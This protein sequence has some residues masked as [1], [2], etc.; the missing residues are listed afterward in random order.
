MAR[1]ERVFI[2]GEEVAQYDGAYKVTKG[3]GKKYGAERV[4]DTPISESGFTGLAIG[5]ALMGLR[6]VLEFMTMNFSLQAVDHIFNSSAKL[7]HMSNG[8]LGGSIV[9]RG[10]NGPAASVAAQ[11]SQCFASMYSNV[12][13]LVVLSPY[14]AEDCKGL[15]KAAIRGPNPTVFLENELLYSKSFRVPAEV[16]SKEFVLPIGKAKVMRYGRDITLVAHSR[17]VG[18]CE[19]AAEA[20]AREGV[21]AEVINLRS[22]KPLDRQAIVRSVVKTGRLV[23]VEDGFPQNGVASEIFM[24]VFEGR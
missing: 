7:L 6:P 5:A 8:E 1:D 13:G 21:S 24:T 16:A 3:L 2:I 12:P 4:W 11:H 18:L 14:D 22:I 15:L 20:L 23:V 10:L 17:M 19:Q 9:I